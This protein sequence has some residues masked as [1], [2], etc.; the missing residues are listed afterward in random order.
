MGSTAFQ[1]L[2]V[3]ASIPLSFAFA[4]HSPPKMLVTYLAGRVDDLGG[5]IHALVADDLA[6]RVLDRGVVA[7]DEVAVYELDRER[8]FACK[9]DSSDRSARRLS[10][11]G[12]GQNK[13]KRDG[14]PTER[15]PTIAILRCFGGAGIFADGEAL[16]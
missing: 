14:V 8:G 3:S 11:A 2:G 15:L 4:R 16:S 1:P 13:G 9:R 5:I 6:E 12:C 10:V 7:L